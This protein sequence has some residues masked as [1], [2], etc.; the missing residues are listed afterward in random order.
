MRGL[1]LLA[2]LLLAGCWTGPPFYAASD[3]VTAL[4]PGI[5][6]MI[7]PSDGESDIE[8]VRVSIRADGMTLIQ[9]E[10]E[11]PSVV[12]LVPLGASG[13]RYVGWAEN[14][15]P[16]AADEEH[17]Y[18]LL[19]ARRGE[20]LLHM[21]LC[22]DEAARIATAAGADVSDEP[23]SPVCRFPDRRSLERA[24]RRLRPSDEDAV[25]LIPLG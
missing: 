17:A 8:K 3:A 22:K 18:W 14:D 10:E 21:P 4:P 6:T 7:S 25:R 5:Y 9:A 23:K 15:D 12:G 19:E 16:A 11:R 24:L 1:I 13:R 20:F 2:M